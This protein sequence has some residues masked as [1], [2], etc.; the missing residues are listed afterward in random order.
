MTESASTPAGKLW[1]SRLPIVLGLAVLAVFIAVPILGA[2]GFTY[3]TLT[4]MFLLIVTAQGWN[5]IGGYTGYAAFGNVAFFGLGA[6]TTAILMDRFNVPFLVTLPLGGLVA[7]LYAVLV[8]LPVLRLRG[9]YFAIATLGVA[10]AT[11][12]VVA[13]A[14]PVTAGATGISLPFLK[15]IDYAQNVF[16]YMTMGLVLFG[17]AL[18]WFFSRRKIGYSWAA[19][20]AD[21]DG[22]KML[23]VNTTSSKVIA[24]ALAALLTGL[25]GSVYAY[26]NSFIAPEEVFKIDRTLQ[27]IL[28]SVLGGA[29]T[30]AGPVVGAMIFQLVNTF[31]IFGKPFGIDLGQFHVTLLGIFIVL[32]IIFTPRGLIDLIIRSAREAQHERAAAG[33]GLPK[34]LWGFISGG[35]QATRTILSQNVRQFRI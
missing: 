16:Y 26:Y 3:R 17:L 2:S 20:R 4:A 11:R 25:A 27:A 33:G 32:V 23:G 14:T 30:L 8:G 10:E 24:F 34:R 18:T 29:G 31:L 15:P 13:W 1:R 5:L 7:A 21:E 22:A 35:W 6:Y 9:H 19:I 12:E 28:A